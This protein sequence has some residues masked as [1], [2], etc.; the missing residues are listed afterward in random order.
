MKRRGRRRSQLLGAST[1]LLVLVLYLRLGPL[2]DGLLDAERVEPS[3][4][5]LDRHGE[6]LYEARSSTGTRGARMAP[7]EIPPLV[8]AATVAAEDRMFRSHWGV[9]PLAIARAAVANL[10][11]WHVVQGGSTLSQQVVSLLEAQHGRPQAR[12]LPGKIREAVLAFR[13]EHHLS[14][15]EILARYLELA[16]YGNQVEGIARAST[17]YFTRTVADLTPAQAAYLATLP[18][19]PSRFNPRHDLTR[20]LP[21]QRRILAEMEASG[22]L[23]A[24]SA[25][26]A[27]DE[28]I[29]VTRPTEELIAPHFVQRVLAHKSQSAG[30]PIQTTLDLALQRDVAGIIRSHRESLRTHHAYNVAVAVLD[31]HTG[32]WLAWEGSGD[33][34]DEAHGGAIDGVTSP[35]QPGSALKPFT[36]AAA[37]EAGWHPGRVLPDIPS[38][39]PTAEAGIV[40]R[41]RNYDGQFRGPMRA[42]LALA[43]SENVPAVAL[44]SEIGVPTVASLLR[45]SGISTLDKTAA[46][47]GLGLTLGNA[48]VRLDELIA[49]YA[50]IARGGLAVA[51]ISVRLPSAQG[52]SGAERIISE[53]AAFW[54][55]D[56]LSDQHALEF[57]SGEGSRLDFPFAVAAKTG[58]SQAYHDNWTLGFTRDVTVGVWVGNFDRTPLRQSSGVTGA[59]PIFHDVMLAAVE[60]TRGFLPLFDPAPLSAPPSDLHD[61]TLCALSGRVAGAACPVRTHEFLPKKYAPQECTGHHA[62]DRGV[63]TVWPEEYREWL[64]NGEVGTWGDGEMARVPAREAASAGLSGVS[65]GSSTTNRSASR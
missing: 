42:R 49:A 1:C 32:E 25:Q 39:F 54:V 61:V 12:S 7:D 31:T 23:D 26:I 59:G 52:A 43:G 5:V 20:A 62:S 33:Y 13:L 9:D 30:A 37:F 34:F 16:P 48:E 41:P 29:G 50:M 21:R 28:R 63:V 64:T 55:T 60:R 56:I 47:Y 58:T 17:F 11:A 40:Y 46:Y 57:V 18:Q 22:V 24:T 3:T 51:P 53:R 14:K 15:D 35:R 6:V 4:I 8:A 36:Y 19:Q 45:R 44:A 10:R 27:Q 65:N 38:Q 2:P